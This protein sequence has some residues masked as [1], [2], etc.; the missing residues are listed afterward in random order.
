MVI[1]GQKVIAGMDKG[2]NMAAL[3]LA[4]AT[5]GTVF[6]GFIAAVAFA[7][8]LAVVA[9][10]TLAGATTLAH[11]LYVNVFRNGQSS[12]EDEVRVAKR[13]TLVLGILAI[14]LGLAFKGQSY[15]FV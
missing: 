11:D 13:A 8:I 6:L 7:T 14:V 10:L 1:V 4:E 3:L 5:G 15:N 2:G 12:E 9:G